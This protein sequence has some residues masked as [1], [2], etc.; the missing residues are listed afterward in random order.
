MDFCNLRLPVAHKPV[1]EEARDVSRK[2]NL[3]Q[4]N[5]RWSF[6]KAYPKELWPVVGRAPFRL[7]LNTDSL[8]QA[9]R[10][11]GFAEQ[12]YWAAVDEAR[13]RLGEV[14]ARPLT[15]I[16]ATAIVSRWF[17]QRN[18]EL[19]HSHLHAPTPHVI[20]DVVRKEL[21]Y[22]ERELSRRLADGDIEEFGALASRVLE[23]EGI[24]VDP[25]S[26]G[27]RT[28]LQ[29]L[30]RANKEL[31]RIDL[32]RLQG[33]FG[34]RPA[35]PIFRDALAA[36][37]TPRRT[38]GDLIDAYERE[39][40]PGWSPSTKATHAPVWR[41]LRDVFG[42]SRDVAT[43]TR[44]DGRRLFETVKGLP[45]GLGKLKALA[46]LPIPKAVEQAA[47]QDLPLIGPSG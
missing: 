27:Y 36:P 9:Q 40:A 10:L 31:G 29:L 12:R 20:L 3:I 47:K 37:A 41:I 15:S 46:G 18:E 6:N 25:A 17:L 39:K 26:E 1:T 38:V 14:I 4:R 32:A 30:V 45:K 11:R 19:D 5:G 2:S 42:T 24:K 16:E 8:E 7:A 34:Y 33:D 13:R 35:D 44:E 22:S 23:R 28:L 21:T 43:I